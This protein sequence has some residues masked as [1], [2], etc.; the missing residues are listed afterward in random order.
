MDKRMDEWTNAADEQRVSKEEKQVSYMQTCYH[1][2]RRT[3]SWLRT[4][5]LTHAK[6]GQLTDAAWWKPTVLRDKAA[7]NRYSSPPGFLADG[8]TCR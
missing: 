8:K 5:D 6:H 3:D 4:P 2:P 7:Y 1:I